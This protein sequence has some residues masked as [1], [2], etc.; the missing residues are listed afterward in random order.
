MQEINF[1]V[2]LLMLLPLSMFADAA[3]P[4]THAC[5]SSGCRLTPGVSIPTPPG[6]SKFF[7]PSLS[8]SLLSLPPFD[9]KGFDYCGNQKRPLEGWARTTG[10]CVA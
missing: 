6:P 8:L 3:T 1:Q 2:L 10:T 7:P 5:S 9:S 4:E